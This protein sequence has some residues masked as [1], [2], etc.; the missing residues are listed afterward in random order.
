MN[1]FEILEFFQVRNIFLTNIKTVFFFEKKTIS[2]KTNHRDLN[3]SAHNVHYSYKSALATI[4]IRAYS[5]KKICDVSLKINERQTSQFLL[6]KKIHFLDTEKI[7][8]C[9]DSSPVP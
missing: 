9:L 5:K 3:N 7:K 2:W 6:E 8:S 4:M 1:I